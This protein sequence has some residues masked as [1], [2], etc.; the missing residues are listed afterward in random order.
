MASGAS[1]I[2][3]IS[4]RF[5]AKFKRRRVTN[6]AKQ[7]R[8]FVRFYMLAEDAYDTERVQAFV[9]IY[10]LGVV[11]LYIVVMGAFDAMP[12]EGQTELRAFLAAYLPFALLILGW[13]VVRPGVNVWRRLTSMTGDFSGIAWMLAHGGSTTLPFFAILLWVVLGTGL[14]FGRK[15]LQVGMV[16]GL[17][18]LAVVT[19]FNTYWQENLYVV[20]AF[21]VTAIVVPV[22]VLAL[23]SH[24][25]RAYEA[26]REA[27]R[28][29]SR[30][31]A[32]ASHDLRQPIHAISLYT[33]CLRDA[34]LQDK[35]LQVVDSIDRSLGQV[36]RL[37]K[38]LLD[39]STLDGGRVTPRR[40]PIALTDVIDDILRQNAETAQRAGAVL[41]GV[42]CGLVVDVDQAL[43]TTMLQNIISNAI[44]YAPGAPI[45]IGCRRRGRTVTMIVCDAGPGIAP[46]HQERVFEEFYQVRERGD[47]DIEGVGLGLPIVRRLAELLDLSVELRSLPGR[48]TC[49]AIAGLPVTAK[50]AR[51][52]KLPPV[53]LA[54]SVRGL[55][56][57]LVEDDDSVRE[58]TATL[59]KGWG[60]DVQ[61]EAGIPVAVA[62]CDLVI[63]DY[64]LGGGLTGTEC[65]HAVRALL[66]RS[67]P[68]VVLTGH[69][70][71][72]VCAEITDV[73]IPVLSK[74]LRPAELRSVILSVQASVMTP[75]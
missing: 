5:V 43:L 70:E 71:A 29:K 24:M 31:M 34:G 6:S 20:A 19:W 63:T 47:R 48:G 72:R 16:M 26:V 14:R 9:R 52:G 57:L 64:D 13:V 25:E 41:R 1:S 28:S 55:H 69:D 10:M 75:S 37:F 74:P 60:C 35:D 65:I 2:K 66:G 30:M 4:A 62:N 51:V 32:H 8:T 58:A 39:I 27:N 42:R 73:S 40:E 33:A 3:T 36:Q 50:P 61:T 23:L 49:V 38:S 15:Y 59:L 67:V 45:V 12:P 17:I 68:A 56:V 22:Y 44:K 11:S 18:C 53:P 46:E 54:P 21:A 7:S